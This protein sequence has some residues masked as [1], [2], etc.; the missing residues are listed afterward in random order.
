MRPVALGGP[1]LV[2]GHTR[3][4]FPVPVQPVY[5]LLRLENSSLLATSI[6]ADGANGVVFGREDRTEVELVA[7]VA[8]QEFHLL[9]CPVPSCCLDLQAAP[10]SLALEVAHLAYPGG[11]RGILALEPG[12][13]PIS[14]RLRSRRFPAE[15]L[16]PRHRCGQ[17]LIG[18][19]PFTLHV[20]ASADGSK[21]VLAFHL[22]F[23][24]HFGAQFLG[25]H[26]PA[27][28]LRFIRSTN[29]ELQPQAGHQGDEEHDLLHCRGSVATAGLSLAPIA[30]ARTSLSQ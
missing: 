1:L 28:A 8:F 19:V 17:A 23:R 5:R 10:R 3:L 25:G 11:G 14:R 30:R 16:V 21:P 20:P 12:K 7:G 26:Q 22:R 9:L 15:L 4:P 2:V 24:V 29:I 13:H 27:F 18:L 6:T